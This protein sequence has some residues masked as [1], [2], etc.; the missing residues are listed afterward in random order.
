M[1][2]IARKNISEDVILEDL[3]SLIREVV[4]FCYGVVGIANLSKKKGK[5]EEGLKVSISSDGMIS[6]KVYLIVSSDVKITET[7]RSTQKSIIYRLQRVFP[8]KVEKVS[9]FVEEIRL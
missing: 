4:P 7:I 5:V 9:V 1:K 8:N 2:K 3:L 6:A